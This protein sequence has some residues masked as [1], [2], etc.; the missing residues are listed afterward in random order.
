IGLHLTPARALLFGLNTSL[1]ALVFGAI[2]LVVSQFTSEARTAAGITGV[3]LGLSFV[4]TSASRVISGGEW[5]GLLSPLHFF[6]LNKPLV[7]GYAVQWSA[8][9]VMA[10]LTAALTVLGVALFTRRDIAAPLT[11]PMLHFPE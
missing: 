5:L 9:S 7:A 8:M 1:F 3:L 11:L 2:A 10:V 4:L 6:E